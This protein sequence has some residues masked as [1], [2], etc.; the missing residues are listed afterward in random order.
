MGRGYCWPKCNPAIIAAILLMAMPAAP[1]AAQHVG[2]GSAPGAGQ[3]AP[4]AISEQIPSLQGQS[5]GTA[6]PENGASDQPEPEGCPLRSR[7]KLD[8]IV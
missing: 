3:E 5:P 1:A 8:L 4:P 2:A 6:Q 7:K